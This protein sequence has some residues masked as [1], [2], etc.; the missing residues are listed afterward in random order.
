MKPYLIAT[1]LLI[2]SASAF[3]K[4][5]PKPHAQ[6]HVISK[7]RDTFYFRVNQELVGGQVK[8]LN[9]SGDTVATAPIMRKHALIDFFYENPGHYKIVICKGNVSQSFDF[10]KKSPSPYVAVERERLNIFQ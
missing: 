8:V 2:A 5:R 9:E 6:V 3:S 7:K 4:E 1:C 10:D